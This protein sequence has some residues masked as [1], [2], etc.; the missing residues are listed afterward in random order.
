MPTAEPRLSKQPA[1]FTHAKLDVQT[2]PLKQL[3]P[4]PQNPRVH[5]E[6]DSP[7]WAQLRK[8]LINVYFD[9]LVWNKR[10]GLLVSG[11][12]RRKVLDAMGVTKADVVV[13]D[14]D[15]DAHL[16]LLMAA[17]NQHGEFNFQLVADIM[18][19]LQERGYDLDL[20]GFNA[21]T[22]GQLS[23]GTHPGMDEDT[24]ENGSLVAAIQ[25]SIAEPTISVRP[26]QVWKA[27]P[28]TVAC[29]DVFKEW[30]RW[31]PLL[32]DGCLFLP[33]G[34]PLVLLTEIAATTPMVVVQPDPYLCGHILDH[35]VE[36]GGDEPT[37]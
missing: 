5:P 4:H 3:L 10:N 17:N 8:S 35:W 29:L 1:A 37:K 26:G 25:V 36:T 6:P 28:H 13:I 33:Y 30:D 11:H 34:G 14:V 19:G 2:L 32:K 27:G 7:E 15:E 12:L 16:A 23:D 9:P 20:T 18:K 22:L 21:E 24:S 31:Q